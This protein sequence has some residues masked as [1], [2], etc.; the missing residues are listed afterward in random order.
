MMLG[1]IALTWLVLQLFGLVGRPIAR[2]WFD[3]LPDG[4]YAFSKIVG[5]LLCGYGVWLLAMIGF[6]GLSLPLIILVAAGVAV[7]G[8]W[9]SASDAPRIPWQRRRGMAFGYE[10]IFLAALVGMALMRSY[11]PDPWG[12][13]RPMDFAFFN[14]IARSPAFPPHDPWLSGYSINYYYFGYLLMAM[15]TVVT[16]A[17]PA[18]GYNLSLATIFALAAL[19][20]AGLV[21]NLIHLDRRASEQPRRTTQAGVWLATAGTAALVLCAGNLVGAAQIASGTALIAALP[22]D[23]AARAL[24]NG[25]GARAPL[26]LD[27]PFRGEYFDGTSQIVPSDQAADFNWWNPSRAIWDDYPAGDGGQPYRRYAITEFPF[28]SFWLGDM[29]PH[30]MAIPLVV[31]AAA[32]GLQLAARRD[33]PRYRR[34]PARLGSVILNGLVIGSMYAVNS[35][36][37]PLGVALVIGGLVIAVRRTP[38]PRAIAPPLR[39]AALTAL[40]AYLAFLPFHATFRS[41]VGARD[42]LIDLPLLGALS[43]TL[44]L[45]AWDRTELHSML[46]IFGLFLVPLVLLVWWAGSSHPM[47]LRAS[48][49]VA[50]AVGTLIGAPL[51]ALL[52]LAVLAG[53]SALE[54]VEQPARAFTLGLVM[55]GSLIC[56]GIDVVYIRDVFESRMNTVFKFTYQVWVIWGAAAGYALWWLLARSPQRWRLARVGGTLLVGVLAAAALVYPWHTFGRQLREATPI[57][58]A[59]QT[60]RDREPGGAAALRFLREQVPGDAV[61]LEASGNGPGDSYDPEGLGI[62]GVS[63][64]TGL[65]TVLGW[66]GHQQQWRAG[67]PQAQAEIAPRQADVAQIYAT[68]DATVARELLARYDVS[69]V[70]VGAAERARYPAEA[71]DKFAG[72]G[73]V[74]FSEEQVTIYRLR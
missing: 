59:G 37:M 21:S 73:D 66:P 49:P 36:D 46:M 23:Q 16:G 35:W 15:L 41:L 68:L 9:W 10:A 52:P 58:L 43:R 2:R 63:A 8:A 65:A 27:P 74:A 17:E 55:L 34:D 44:G 30:V 61:I 69:Y 64:S 11:Q 51:L 22:G 18:V 47:W 29:H 25:L 12:T 71:L 1:S 24:L 54:R 70:Y 33:G 53:A 62:G 67:D 6:G 26:T 14:A 31:L 32:A 7:A 60:P 48:L 57:G 13:E 28:F 72:L 19:G 3:A 20:I 40:V 38:A 4:G 39:Q 45:V 50:L 5:I 42:P 56:L